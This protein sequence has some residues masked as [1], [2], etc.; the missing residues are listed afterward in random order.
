[1]KEDQ[2]M[3]AIQAQGC[4]ERLVEQTRILA[5]SA[6]DQGDYLNRTGAGVDEMR[7]LF[8]DVGSFLFPL[9]REYHLIDDLDEASV[10][11]IEEHLNVEIGN[12]AHYQEFF[13]SWTR[14]KDLT[15]WVETRRLASYA[16][17]ILNRPASARAAG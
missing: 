13:Y 14:A 8:L 17:G 12:L 7:M 1:M 15:Y 9:Y 11:A 2:P 6:G 16:L 3:T 10:L 4:F 5:S